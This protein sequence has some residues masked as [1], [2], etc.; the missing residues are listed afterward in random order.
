[1]S[2]T[3]ARVAEII[4]THHDH[5]WGRLP[6]L[7]PMAAR[8]ERERGPA[9]G[10]RLRRLIGE[11]HALLFAHLDREDRVLLAIA[12]SAAAPEVH[13]RASRLHEEHAVVVDLLDRIRGEVGGGFHPGP[14]AGPTERLLCSELSELDDHLREQIRLE[15]AVISPYL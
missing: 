15:E 5:V 2:T 4:A 6:F 12:H 14:D 11:L 13:G 7:A 9:R 3:T 10:G 1:M 8:V